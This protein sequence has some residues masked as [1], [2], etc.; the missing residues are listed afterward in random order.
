MRYDDIEAGQPVR[1]RSCGD[2]IAR[3]KDRYRSDSDECVSVFDEYGRYAVVSPEVLD[4][5]DD[6]KVGLVRLPYPA[7]QYGLSVLRAPGYYGVVEPIP[8]LKTIA[9]LLALAER[10][11]ACSPNNEGET[12]LWLTAS[13]RSVF[14]SAMLTAEKSAHL[15]STRDKNVRPYLQALR[16]KLASAEVAAAPVDAFRVDATVVHGLAPL[17]RRLIDE[18]IPHSVKDDGPGF[19]YIKV[20]ISSDVFLWAERDHDR[21]SSFPQD[22]D[23]WEVC[24]YLPD[25]DD[26]VSLGKYLTIDAALYIVHGCRQ[27]AGA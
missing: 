19:T 7:P 22:E 25:G 26:T 1:V 20:P 3:V 27:Q 13:E 6:P 5:A 4:T 21:W 15:Q 23:G 16:E 8:A 12:R 14:A 9:S 2:W 10:L 18:G 24:R 17:L 11:H